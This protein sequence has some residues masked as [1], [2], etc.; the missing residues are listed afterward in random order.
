MSCP[1]QKVPTKFSCNNILDRDKPPDLQVGNWVRGPFCGFLTT[2][3]LCRTHGAFPCEQGRH[4]TPSYLTKD[5]KPHCC[6]QETHH[7]NS[8]SSASGKIVVLDSRHQ[9]FPSWLSG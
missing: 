3:Y 8:V 4:G 5:Y 7:T 2:G 6:R 9:E 1:K